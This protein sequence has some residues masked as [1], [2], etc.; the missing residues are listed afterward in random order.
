MAITVEQLRAGLAT[1]DQELP[2]LVLG[3]EDGWDDAAEPVEMRLQRMESSPSYSGKYQDIEYLGYGE[4]TPMK[5]ICIG[6]AT[7]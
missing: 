1:F 3:Y 6:K 5:A 7:E 4:G 2:V